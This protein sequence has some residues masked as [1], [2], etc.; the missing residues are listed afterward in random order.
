MVYRVA[1]ILAVS[2]VSAANA[3]TKIGM[4]T[5]SAYPQ[6]KDALQVLLNWAANSS[7]HNNSF[8][9]TLYIEYNSSI[10][11]TQVEELLNASINVLVT[12]YGSGATTAVIKAVPNNTAMPILVWGGA[13]DDIFK[14]YCT[15]KNLSCF[16]GLTVASQYAVPSLEAIIAKYGAQSVY[17]ITN[18]NGFS[19]K[20][21]D[22][23]EAYIKES[24]FLTLASSYEISVQKTDLT[25]SDIAIVDAAVNSTPDVFLI[26][27]HAGDVEQVVGRIRNTSSHQPKAIIAVNGFTKPGNYQD[28]ANMNFLIMPD[29]WA[30]DPNMNDTIVGWNST[31]FS[32]AVAALGNPATYHHAS[33][34][35]LF[36]M[37][38]HAVNSLG[39]TTVSGE[40][41]ATALMGLN[42]TDTFY[43][44]MDWNTDGTVIKPMYGMQEQMGYYKMVAPFPSNPLMPLVPMKCGD[45]KEAYRASECCEN[46]TKIFNELLTAR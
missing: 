14:V 23:A 25:A 28:A 45:V 43:G 13:S 24:P 35:G 40:A 20:V 7:S 29:Q 39:N 30:K 9:A 16:A 2:L 4:F 26:S 5:Q 44:T 21:T 6:S 34:G 31:D 33:A 19:R 42:A 3:K 37:L 36:V 15:S 11:A 32:S 12:P 38:V 18:N 46:P 8:D 17:S 27:G 41:L 22:G 1:A 10:V